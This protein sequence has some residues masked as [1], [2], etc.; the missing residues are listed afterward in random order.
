MI[1]YFSKIYFGMRHVICL[2]PNV[3][4]LPVGITNGKPG[5]KGKQEVF[6]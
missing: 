3:N 6:V 2:L 1:Y 4:L 5:E